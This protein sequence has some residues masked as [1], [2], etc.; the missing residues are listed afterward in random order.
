[1]VQ[2]TLDAI[3][4][5][6]SARL[7]AGL[8][9]LARDVNLAEEAAQEA[10]VEALE[11]WPESGVP[12]NPGAWLATTARRRAIDR[13]RR[14]RKMREIGEKLSRTTDASD[15]MTDAIN[16]LDDHIED[17]LLRLIFMTSHPVLSE[18]ARSALTLR[19]L[20]GLSTEEIARA[21]LVPESTI[22]QRIV[23]AK[24]TLGENRAEFE[25]PVGAELEDRITSVLEV[26]YLLFNEGYTATS[27][28]NWIR[29]SLCEEAMRLGRIL[30]G[31]LPAHAEVHGLVA[32]MELQASRFPA[33]ADRE[34]NP[35]LLPDQNRAK[36]DRTLIRH[37]LAALDSA[38]R[39]SDASRPYT[40]QA[41]IAACHAR[42]RVAE[43][44]D[45]RRIADLYERLSLLTGSPI[46]E[47]NR[48]VAVSMAEGPKAGLRVLDALTGNSGTVLAGY[49][50]L[51]GVRADLLMKLDRL[52]EAAEEFERAAT[53]T[54]NE[55]E[56]SMLLQ[57]AEACRG[58]LA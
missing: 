32:L 2:R 15:S 14:D 10:F 46:V 8:V 50:L 51:P 31:L 26:L 33:R 39:A 44:T 53:M 19:L 30:Q 47:L 52:A 43:E 45:W 4:K 13:I 7:I 42:A 5:I 3:W 36:W 55:R 21:F 25:E 35:I 29:P 23:R 58:K 48:A 16:K 24:R 22:A 41:E 17:D 18:D 54:R 37:G 28:S 38:Q 12:E 49:H 20:C 34:G 9:R 40:L 56:Q 1:M 11:R 27:G 6:E 57:R